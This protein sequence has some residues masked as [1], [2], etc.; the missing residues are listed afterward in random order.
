MYFID[1]SVLMGITRIVSLRIAVSSFSLC[2]NQTTD[3]PWQFYAQLYGTLLVDE[4]VYN[5]YVVI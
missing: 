2:Y 4:A 5:Y 1:T 3:E